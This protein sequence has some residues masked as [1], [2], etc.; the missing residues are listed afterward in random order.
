MNLGTTPAVVI[1]KSGGSGSPL[2]S[3]DALTDDFGWTVQAVLACLAFAFLVCKLFVL[4]PI[5]D[6][7]I[8]EVSPDFYSKEIL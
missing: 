1:D 3:K 6:K 4:F 5:F 8:V 2:C 7:W